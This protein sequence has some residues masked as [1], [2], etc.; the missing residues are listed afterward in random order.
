MLADVHRAL[1]VGGCAFIVTP[2][3]RRSFKSF[4]EDRNHIHPYVDVSLRAAIGAAGLNV[5][6]LTHTNVR[7]PLGRLRPLWEHI[8]ALL[9]TGS[10][11][12]AVA[13]RSS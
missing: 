7:R 1:K 13:Q 6:R 4:Y 2:D 8:P 11:L 3:F 9:F 5:V 10:A 12:L